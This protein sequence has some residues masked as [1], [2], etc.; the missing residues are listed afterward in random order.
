MLRMDNAAHYVVENMWA[1]FNEAYANSFAPMTLPPEVPLCGFITGLAADEKSLIVYM[2]A[3]AE[4]PRGTTPKALALDGFDSLDLSTPPQDSATACQV[5]TR[6][7]TAKIGQALPFAT[8]AGQSGTF[9]V[10][11]APSRGVVA[12]P[13]GAWGQRGN[14]ISV[15]ITV[16]NQSKLDPLNSNLQIFSVNANG[17]LGTPTTCPEPPATGEKFDFLGPGQTVSGSICFAADV[18]PVGVLAVLLD[19][20]QPTVVGTVAFGG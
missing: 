18:E 5:D 12:P 6:R 16:A 15:P 9:T 2:Y 7:F 10:T 3:T 20:Q 14:A 17:V 8:S 19:S 1:W 4:I 13:S 11:G